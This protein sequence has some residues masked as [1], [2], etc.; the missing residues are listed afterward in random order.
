MAEDR[1][2]RGS[3]RESEKVNGWPIPL[4]YFWTQ[5]WGYCDSWGRGRR[6]PRLVYAGTF[7]LD[8]EVDAKTVERW[9]HALETAGVIESYEVGGKRYF[10]CVNWP[11]HQEITYLKK[12]DI[13]DRFGIVPKAGKNSGKVPEKSRKV[14][15]IPAQGEGEGE[16]EGEIEGE[17][18]SAGAL[19]P[20]C[21]KHP[22]GTDKPCRACGNAR[23]VYDAA[24][25][26]KK[27]KPTVP[28][29]IPEPDC[30][31]HPGRPLRGCNRCAE[32][33]AS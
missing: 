25:F 15:N 19:T 14:Q 8:E 26:A 21:I 12:T 24:L 29:I 4:R 7:P 16:V 2:I 18:E 23:R 6:D 10:E 5:L 9:L 30:P 1:M 28:G 32:E 11:E 17:G 31:T 27:H 13:P 22:S 33:L 20:F 3:M